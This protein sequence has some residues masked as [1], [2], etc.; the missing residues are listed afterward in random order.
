MTAMAKENRPT[1]CPQCGHKRT[2]SFRYCR[3]CGFDF[4]PRAEVAAGTPPAVEPRAPAA[5][6]A[7]RPGTNPFG[8]WPTDEP[9]TSRT[10]AGGGRQSAATVDR[11]PARDPLP[12]VPAARDFDLVLAVAVLLIAALLGAAVAVLAG[13]GI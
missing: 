2:A 1:K 3:S 5:D 10:S 6:A 13:G 12:L 9:S 4:E 11:P 7:N 8:G